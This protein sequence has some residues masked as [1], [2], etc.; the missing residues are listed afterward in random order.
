MKKL[1]QK[2][3]NFYTVHKI[4]SPF[5]ARE[6]NWIEGFGEGNFLWLMTAVCVRNSC[7]YNKETREKK[8]KKQNHEECPT[9]FSILKF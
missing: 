5:K 9:H 4:E 3:H 6:E 1:T 8:Q 2:L 7:L